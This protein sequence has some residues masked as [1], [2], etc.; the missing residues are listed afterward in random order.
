[1]RAILYPQR[2]DDSAFVDDDHAAAGGA[3]ELLV[4]QHLAVVGCGLLVESG[5]WNASTGTTTGSSTR[6]CQGRHITSGSSFE[7]SGSRAAHRW[8]PERIK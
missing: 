4:V 7:A 5:G 3:L 6:S 8:F 2:G 1:L